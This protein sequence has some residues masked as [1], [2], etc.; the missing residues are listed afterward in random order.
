MCFGIGE[1]HCMK[2]GITGATGF[3]G[4]Y[5][6][7]YLVEKTPLR[8]R[9]LA[10]TLSNDTHR[11]NGRIEWMAG[12]LNSPTVCAD[13]VDGLDSVIHLAHTNIP[14]TSNRDL[15]GDARAN[16][17]PS[18]NLLESIKNAGRC[19]HLLYA[20]SGGA[21]YGCAD[22][23]AR[24]PLS[25]THPCNP[26]TSYGI[27]KH[28][29]E[30]YLRMAVGE[31]WSKATAL[32]IGNPYGVLLPPER[33]QGFIGIALHRILQGKPVRIIGDPENVRDYIHLR[34]LC[35]FFECALDAPEEFQIYNV[36]SGQGHSV[37]QLL[38]IMASIAGRQLEREVLNY[39]ESEKHLVPWIILSNRKAAHQLGWSPCI[40]VEEGLREMYRS[41][42]R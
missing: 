14:L 5:L 8:I 16:L 37:N 18:L 24:E 32:R 39:T 3:I 34:D 9:A 21:I 41:G 15:P 27:Q 13:F 7:D 11:H 23:A 2:L 1:T 40:S 12:D 30:S 6:L 33:M 35:R 38:D 42:F 19:A 29:F 31:G 10:R 4:S 25:E 28:A 26:V 36:G 22:M 17:I 20:S